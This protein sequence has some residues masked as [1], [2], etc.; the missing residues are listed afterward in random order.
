MSKPLALVYY[1]NLLPGSQLPGRLL[2]LGYRV[3]SANS[4]A[5]LPEACAGDMPLVIIAE[6][7]P[8]DEACAAI[9]RLRANPATAHIPVLGFARTHSAA[10]QSQARQAG[11]TLLAADAGMA[12]QLP[13]LLERILQVE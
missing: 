2:D 5:L 6:L 13:Q 7:A 1:S 8:L 9:A 11:V 12:E 3:Q 4:A 10:A